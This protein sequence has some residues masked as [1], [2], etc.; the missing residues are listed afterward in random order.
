MTLNEMLSTSN[1]QPPIGIS[2][3]ARRVFASL[4][5]CS[6]LLLA[7]H[8]LM[9]QV[10]T[11]TV[12]GTVTD[13]TGA[14]VANATVIITNLATNISTTLTT[15]NTGEYR[16]DLVPVGSYS[17]AV[18]A[19]GFEKVIQSN[20]TLTVNQE[21]RVDETLKVGGSN[22]TVTVNSDPP[23][24][25]LESAVVERTLESTEVD[26][27]PI[28]NRNIYNLLM[29][30][31]GVQNNTVG[32]NT[33]GYNQEVLQMNGG[34]T[35][36]NN[37]TVSYYLDGG[38]NMTSLRNTGND[39]PNPEA[40]EEFNIQTS[41][42]NA[43]YGRMSSGV[44]SALTKSGGNNLHGSIY[45][46]NRNT[47]FDASN[48]IN[49]GGGVG[50]VHR[51]MYGA[52]LG[53]PIRKDKTF[54][55]GEFAGVR[56]IQPANF[57]GSTLPT[58]TGG[59][60]G[61][62][63]AAGDFSAYLPS[64]TTSATAACGGTATAF[65]VCS[66]TT[67]KPYVGAN[68]Y[69]SNIITDPL[70]PTAVN[71]M[72][73]LKGFENAT[74]TSGGFTFPSYTGQEAK[75]YYTWEAMGKI[76]HQI[77]PKQRLEGTYFYVNG[78]QQIPA[79]SPSL[80][81][82]AQSQIWT[83][84]V[85]NASDTYTLSEHKINQA[86]LTWTRIIGG[87]ENITN[88]GQAGRESLANF[89]SSLAVQGP[90]SLSQITVTGYFTLANTIDGP[91]AGT[92][93]YSARD[94]FIWNTGK[95]ELSLG[96]EA[97]LNKDDQ[98]TDLN[99]YGVFGFS[100]STT[101]RTG[102]ALSDFVLGQINSTSQDA[103]VDAID[104]SFFYSLFAQDNYRILPRL[105]FNLGLRWDLQTAPTDPQNK[106]ST[107]VAG[108]QSTVN[109]NMPLGELVV[110][111]KGVTRGT[112]GTSYTHF[113][114]R[115]GFAYDPFGNGKTS[116]RASA[117]IFW[118]GVSGN[119]W[120][121]TSNYYPFSLRYTFPAQGTLTNPYKGLTTNPFPYVYTPGSVNPIVAG[122]S[123]EGAP[124]NF[125]WPKTYQLTM[126]VQQQLSRSS[127]VS[128]AYVGA[129]ARNI[130]FSTDANYPVFNTA[131]PTLN[132]SATVITRRPID[133]GTLG[134][135]LAVDSDQTSNY[136]ALVFTFSQRATKD[137]S[138]NGFYTWSKNIDST[139]LNSSTAPEDYDNLKIDKGPNDYDQR[140]QFAMSIVWQPNYFNKS[141]H[142]VSS[143]LNGWH[144]S[145]V[146]SLHTGTPFNI[147][148]G[149]DNNNDGNT[150]DR[151]V[152]LANPFNTGTNRSSRS[153]LA[154]EFYNPSLAVAATVPTTQTWCGYSTKAPADCVGAGPGGSDG[155]FERNGLYGPGFRDVDASLF[156]D[157]GLTERFKL[158]ARAEAS[159]VFNLVSLTGPN[160]TL[161]SATAGTI[162]GA[163]S[164]RQIQLGIRMM[165]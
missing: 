140:S 84:Q 71:I 162:T 126:S 51:N 11:A 150:T 100:S 88:A 10:T 70:D 109:P 13:S 135:I 50:I 103:P 38:L 139:T 144:F 157:F 158:Q 111:D 149:S 37:G 160:A 64:A 61:G 159:N 163:S 68:G 132:T 2:G 156:R 18:T 17:L 121:A 155:T 127:A 74:V 90:P 96:G 23:Q 154:K 146:I 122:G 69:A 55:F 20:I 4:L 41:N 86:W 54:F 137:V 161:S 60:T 47:D 16:F 128:L 81:W 36:N 15:T 57:S 58:F 119:E 107:F 113:S 129:L 110:G 28:L 134:Q 67:H 80:P 43:S 22:Q 40:L 92:D 138:F 8:M 104:N 133:T 93:F 26:N 106:E 49:Q 34:T 65:V 27:L 130:S 120:N 87:R 95:H 6:L 9:A 72:K 101:A 97:S 123:I 45:E 32:G 29:L 53:G 78:Y 59:T 165:F 63:E 112:V 124:L 131:T 12:F 114:P 105:T 118:G 62:G 143:V 94:L 3:R 85:L 33:L 79:G 152:E 117:G 30:V 25:N 1:S 46:F 99:N 76:D 21:Q 5:L 147:T 75:S 89:G 136:N 148:T 153:A 142:F 42:Y 115:V 145:S 48:P 19:A 151:P 83:Q 35:S 141:N 66:P 82:V 52:T 44:L 31:P 77:S 164:M 39:M 24:I 98:V 56:Q 102:N 116:V 125:K 108:Q 73:Y 7:P 14:I 91:K